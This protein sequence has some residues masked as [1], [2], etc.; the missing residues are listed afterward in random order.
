MPSC[1]LHTLIE[2]I[3][4]AECHFEIAVTGGGSSTVSHLLA[5][6]GASRSLLNAVVPYSESSLRHYLGTSPHQACSESTARM[7]ATRAFHN[8]RQLCSTRVIGIGATAALQTD[9]T[10]RGDDQIYVAVQSEENTRVYS[11]QLDKNK[12]REQQEA[13]CAQ[14]IIEVIA[15]NLNVQVLPP[16]LPIQE[17][18][19]EGS[20]QKLLLGDIAVTTSQHYEAILPGAFNPPHQAHFDIRQLAEQKLGTTVA[21]ELS[22]F[23]VDKPPLDFIDLKQRQDWL[24]EAPVVFTHAATFLEKSALFPGA[25]FVVGIDTLKRIDESKYYGGSDSAKADAIAQ[26]KDDGHQFLV[27]GRAIDNHF[28]TLS[29]VQI[30]QNLREL[31]IEVAEE[32]YRLDISSTKIRTVHL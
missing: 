23:N 29:N 22:A 11:L 5:I 2:Q 6:P 26:F 8:A 12:T 19:G 16:I 20:W 18:T 25:T 17:Q 21:F 30:S 15:T 28:Q 32:E 13:E 3:H 24:G 4:N 1:N 31:C 9:R 7:L 27:F 10:R 14:L